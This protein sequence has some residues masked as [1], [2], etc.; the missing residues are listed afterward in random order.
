MYY[1]QIKSLSIVT[2]QG[3]VWHITKLDRFD[4]D[5][6]RRAIE[7]AII[8]SKEN[9]DKA[10]DLFLKGCYNYGVERG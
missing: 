3:K 1:P 7:N 2:N 4:F 8:K 9:G 10:V 6:A 5:E